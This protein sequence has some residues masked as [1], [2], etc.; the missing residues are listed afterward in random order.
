MATVIVQELPRTSNTTTFL[1]WVKVI[2]LLKN[3]RAVCY[4][5]WQPANLSAWPWSVYSIDI[6]PYRSC[7][8]NFQKVQHER[9]Q[10]LSSR[11]SYQ[12]EKNHDFSRSIFPAE[13]L[14][15]ASWLKFIV[16]LELIQII[17]KAVMQ[18]ERWYYLKAAPYL[19]TDEWKAI[20][21]SLSPRRSILGWE[22]SPFLSF[23]IVD[24]NCDQLWNNR[25]IYAVTVSR[26]IAA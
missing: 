25:Q 9:G 20:T 11:L 12:K 7:E 6:L 22:I 8:S 17:F 13:S 15:R 4:N 10:E 3:S 19:P 18:A 23:L 5:G 26:G 21:M 2:C 16:L 24:A 14:E 1:K